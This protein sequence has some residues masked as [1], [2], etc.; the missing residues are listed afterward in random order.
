MSK[1]GGRSFERRW[2]EFRKE[3]NATN[4]QNEEDEQEKGRNCGGW[5]PLDDRSDIA[6][7]P[8][9]NVPPEISTIVRR[10]RTLSSNLT[11]TRAECDRL[12]TRLSTANCRIESLED[13]AKRKEV[14]IQ[15][16][17]HTRETTEKELEEVRTE[18]RTIKAR[19]RVW[20]REATGMR[21]L[22]DTYREREGGE[23][24]ESGDGDVVTGKGISS[25]GRKSI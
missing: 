9:E 20:K 21:G 1:D 17:K 5:V 13:E 16:E 8:D 14:V 2:E 15:N 19:E 4:E 22:L 10:L 24:G 23:G 25:L 6:T 3:Q 7:Q 12:T 18:C 11:T